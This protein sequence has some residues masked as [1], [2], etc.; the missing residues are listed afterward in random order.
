MRFL[1]PIL[2][3]T[4]ILSCTRQT[5]NPE[6]TAVELLGHLEYLASDSLKGRLPGTLEDLLAADYIA[7]EFRKAGLKWITDDGLQEFELITDLKKGANNTFTSGEFGSVPDSSFAPLPFTANSK[8]EAEVVF[9]G[10]GFSISGDELTWDDYDNIDVSGKWVMV[11]RGNA[12]IDSS[13]SPFHAYS[14]ERDKAML[15]S[16]KGAKGILFVSGSSFDPED[17]LMDLSKREGKVSIPCIHI[18]RSIADQILASSGKSIEELETLM[19]EQRKPASFEISARVSA[20]AEVLPAMETTYN[21]IAYL[22]GQHPERRKNIIIIG[23]H[24]DH[25]GLGGEGS[26]SR[27]PDTIAVHNGADDNAS[28]VAA[29][30]EIAEKISL[31]EPAPSCSY[32]F[33]AFGAEESGLLG[34]KYYVDNPLFPID[35]TRLML[36][37]D[38]VGRMNGNHLQVGGIGTSVESEDIAKAAGELDSMDMSFSYEGYGASDHSSFYGKDI[39]VFFITSGAHTDYH[40]PGDDVE[41][42][43]LDGMVRITS[44]I[45]HILEQVD[46]MNN[47]LTFQE[48]GP[49][50]QY[51]GRNNMRITLGIMPDFTDS[52]EKEGMRVDF[53]TPGKPAH[54]GGMEKGDYIMAIDGNPVNGIYDYM[55][56]LNKFNKGQ[57]IIVTIKRND[58]DL[59]LLI[60]L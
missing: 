35:S 30:I 28:G 41:K 8:L 11:L 40:T 16:D 10:Y 44:F 50:V 21:V 54:I 2:A 55:Y 26:S 46:S 13:S 7:A 36:N 45:D 43:N 22:E 25:L 60:R 5:E 47:T 59:D 19:N 49:K 3:L 38:M 42:I 14:N 23:A 34:S 57:A 56:R 27:Q 53:V 4:L 20:S 12:E 15:A 9:T 33:I 1:G 29:L 31:S 17:I 39:P 18:Q 24:Y 51:S 52:D 32:L 37:L 48:A 6:V 58:K